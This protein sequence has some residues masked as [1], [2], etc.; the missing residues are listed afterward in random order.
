MDLCEG[1]S[2]ETTDTRLP[3]SVSAGSSSLR[4]AIVAVFPVSHCLFDL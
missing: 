2:G 3:F 1:L 4:E